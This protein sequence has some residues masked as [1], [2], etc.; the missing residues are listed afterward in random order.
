MAQKKTRNQSKLIMEAALALAARHGWH[1]VQLQD[2][3]KKTKISPKTIQADFSDIWDILIFTLR[4]IEKETTADVKTR[5]GGSWRDNLFE[6]LMTRFDL[7]QKNRKAFEKIIP[8]LAKY[9][10]A[11]PRMARLF[12]ETMVKM[13]DLS[14]LPDTSCRPLQ[15]IAFSGIYLSLIHA[16]MEDDTPDLSKTMA[17]IDQRLTIFD[18][19][20]ISK[21]QTQDNA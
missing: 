15:I 13:L 6:I 17:A 4:S 19:Y 2:I 14:G 11:L 21:R 8:S 18:Q 16:W 10:A 5:L 9:P 12:P 3:A 20:F 7:A 1:R